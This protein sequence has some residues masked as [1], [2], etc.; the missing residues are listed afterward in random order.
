MNPEE[1]RDVYLLVD[2]V[3]FR[4]QV[5][6]N[7]LSNALRFSPDGSHIW[8]KSYPL[9]EDVFAIEIRDEGIGIPDTLNGHLFDLNKKTTRPGTAGDTGTGLGLH[10]VKSFIDAYGGEIS[11]ESTE[12]REG[13]PSSTTVRLLL[14]GEKRSS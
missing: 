12:G 2:E 5:M 13:T 11:I 10:I 6:G 3:S 8:I 7:I 1:G 4:T 9:R 14:R